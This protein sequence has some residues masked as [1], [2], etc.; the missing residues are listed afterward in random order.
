[1]TILKHYKCIKSNDEK[2]FAVGEIYPLYKGDKNYIVDNSNVRWYEKEFPLIEEQMGVELEEKNKMLNEKEGQTYIITKSDK[3]W[4]TEGKEYEA[5]LN[6]WGELCL[7][8]DDGDKWAIDYLNSRTF[9][10]LELKE[11]QSKIT[12]EDL[13]QDHNEQ[14]YSLQDVK[15]AIIEAYQLYDNDSQRLAFL[16]GYF[17]K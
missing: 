14:K 1:M 15:E 11:K 3:P 16:K 4:W 12:M 17:A 9:Y 10:K 5:V 2:R 13:K 6:N 8:D 7:V